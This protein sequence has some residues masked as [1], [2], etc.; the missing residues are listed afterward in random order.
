MLI[1][2]EANNALRYSGALGQFARDLIELIADAHVRDYR[3]LLFS[4]RI[5][6][7]FRGYFSGHANVSTYLPSGSSRLLSEAWLRY[8]LN[9]I[10]KE[11]KV[12]LFHGLNEE[13]PYHIGRE[14]KTVVTCYEVGQHRRGSLIDAMLWRKRME[15][16]FASADVVVAVSDRVRDQLLAMGVDEGKIE[17]I[18]VEGRPYEATRDMAERYFDLYRRLVGPQSAL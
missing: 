3:A 5:K 4:T 18:G 15:Y 17:V 2:Y 13:L 12:K 9:P 16:A 14:V 11:E 1:G 7:E 8:R 6:S 10:L